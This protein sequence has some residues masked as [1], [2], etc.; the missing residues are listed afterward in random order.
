M[1]V[2]LRAVVGIGLFAAFAGAGSAQDLPPTP[3]K[4]APA[5]SPAPAPAL[6]QTSVPTPNAGKQFYGEQPLFEPVVY[7]S[8][9]LW[10][11]DLLIGAPTGLRLQRQLDHRRLW[12]EFGAGFYLAWP[13]VFAGIR[14]EGPMFNSH[15]DLLSVRPGITAFYLQGWEERHGR[16]WDGIET[17]MMVALDFDLSWRHR[18]SSHFHTTL[19]LKLGAGVAFYERDAFVLPLAGLSLGFNY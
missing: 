6:V 16:Y 8:E 18:W 13:T 5:P 11:A 1:P 19:A 7:E 14:S 2:I 9:P 15:S 10:R 4:P 3:I 12:A 17:A